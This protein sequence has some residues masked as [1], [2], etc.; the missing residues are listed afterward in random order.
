VPD[1]LRANYDV[2]RRIDVRAPWPDGDEPYA[3]LLSY[4]CR[5]GERPYLHPLHG[6]GGGPALTQDRPTDHPWQHG[7]FTGLHEVDGLDFWHEQRKSSAERGVIRLER[8]TDLQTDG[9]SVSW[10]AISSWAGVDRVRRL[11]ETQAIAVRRGDATYYKVDLLW[12][13]RAAEDIEIGRYDYGGLAVRPITHPDREHV[14]ANGETGRDTSEVRAAWCDVS[15]PYDGT[16]AWTAEDKLA[17]AWY[18]VAVF[19]HPQNPTYPTPWRVDG[20]GLINPAPSLAG[21][22]S[23]ADGEEV[24]FAYRLI[25]HAGKADPD[26][27]DRLHEEFAEEAV[28]GPEY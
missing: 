11:T 7:V 2:G 19:D 23:I 1:A 3:P 10:R 13:L 9:A 14:N 15:A 16:R 28:L 4:H 17:G 27:L 22:W 12:T 8:L 6:P 24:S 25:V 20:H 26:M 21:A 5:P 18:G